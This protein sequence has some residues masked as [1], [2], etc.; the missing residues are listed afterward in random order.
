MCNF[1]EKNERLTT[2]KKK[3]YYLSK[4]TTYF[5]NESILYPYVNI[6]E[7][8]RGLTLDNTDYTDILLHIEN[9]GYAHL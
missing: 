2:S 7:G 3:G 4:K 8:K 5:F 6:I 1:L 9:N